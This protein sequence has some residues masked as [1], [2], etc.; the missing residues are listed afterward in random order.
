MII[1]RFN[2]GLGNQMFQYAMYLALKKRNPGITVLADCI[3]FKVNKTHNGFELPLTYNVAL[4]SFFIISNS[5]YAPYG[6]YFYALLT[7]IT[8]FYFQSGLWP[9]NFYVKDKIQ[10]NAQ[11][12]NLDPSKNYYLEGYW[13]S[14]KYFAEYRPQLLEVFT[15]K[16]PGVPG[17]NELSKSIETTTSSISIHI[18]RGN[19]IGSGFHNLAESYY[20]QNSIEYVKKKIE[21]PV[22]YI[23]SDDIAWC[24]KNMRCFDS[25]QHHYVEGYEGKHSYVDIHLMSLCKHNIIANSTFS[26]WGGWLNKNPAKVV[27]CPSELF[28]NPEKNKKVFREFYPAS[29][30][31][32]RS[33]KSEKII[34]DE[35]SKS[36]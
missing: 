17:T 35:K 16:H 11:L 12:L 21:N 14:E 22:F 13:G 7:K 20:Y 19:Y 5:S 33:G 8:R 6:R 2:G 9:A 18:R 34:S 15:S 24:K 23:F 3:S 29:W 36:G 30:I 4:D 10:F 25:L 1:V 32:I 26:W 31:K 28:N 27:I